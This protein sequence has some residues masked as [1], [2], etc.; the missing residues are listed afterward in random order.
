MLGKPAHSLDLEPFLRC[1]WSIVL[2]NEV[3]CARLIDMLS[4]N[5]W[6][7]FDSTIQ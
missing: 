2:I 5:R 3:G 1:C 6:F 7:G 4:K